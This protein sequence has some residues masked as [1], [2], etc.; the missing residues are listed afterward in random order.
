MRDA[1]KRYVLQS[2]FLFLLGCSSILGDFGDFAAQ[3]FP[4]VGRACAIVHFS[5]K[6]HLP[7][8]CAEAQKHVTFPNVKGGMVGNYLR[9]VNQGMWDPASEC[10]ADMIAVSPPGDASSTVSTALLRL[11]TLMGNIST[12]TFFRARANQTTSEILGLDNLGKDSHEFY[13]GRPIPLVG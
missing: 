8:G 7:A 1:D 5:L 10:G 6:D 13:T 2:V 3:P 12:T 9:I 11:T 4:R